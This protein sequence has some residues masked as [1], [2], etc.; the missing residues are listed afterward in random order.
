M[1]IPSPDGGR[2]VKRSVQSIRT[3][4]LAQKKRIMK[5]LLC[6]KRLGSSKT[7]MTIVHLKMRLIRR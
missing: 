3:Q 2:E 7:R 6:L 5:L 4:K 1:S